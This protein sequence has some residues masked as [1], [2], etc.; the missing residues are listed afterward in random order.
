MCS[1]GTDEYI[2]VDGGAVRKAGY[3]TLVV[4]LKGR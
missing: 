3:D 1:I 4:L 2:A